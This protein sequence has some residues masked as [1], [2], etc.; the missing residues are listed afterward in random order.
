MKSKLCDTHLQHP[1]HRARENQPH[2]ITL[3]LAHQNI[4]S[5]PSIC[6]PITVIQWLKFRG[7]KHSS[8]HY[9]SSQYARKQLGFH[10]RARYKRFLWDNKNGKDNTR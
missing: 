9:R 6:P 8:D 3:I 4:A 2:T 10:T 7:L 5:E 1:N